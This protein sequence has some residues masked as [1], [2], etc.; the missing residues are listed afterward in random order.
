MSDD[1]LEE[2]RIE[3]EDLREFKRVVLANFQ[4][5][6]DKTQTLDWPSPSTNCTIPFDRV[7]DKHK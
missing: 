5:L 1:E 6:V 3:L 2:M 7:Y 4:R